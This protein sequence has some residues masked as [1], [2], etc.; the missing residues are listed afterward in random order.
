MIRILRF[1][2]SDEGVKLKGLGN[3]VRIWGF[4]ITV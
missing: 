1:R 3:R 4:G 2:V